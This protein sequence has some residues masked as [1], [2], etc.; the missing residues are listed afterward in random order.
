MSISD[1][2]ELQIQYTGREASNFKPGMKVEITIKNEV[3]TGEVVEPTLSEDTKVYEWSKD[4]VRF[5][6]DKNP[7][8]VKKDDMVKVKLVLETR[9]MR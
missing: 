8:G 1:D 5:K 2:R 9:K 3:Y 7:D 4:A 6:M